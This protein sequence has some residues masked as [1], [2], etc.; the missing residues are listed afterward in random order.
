MDNEDNPSNPPKPVNQGE[1]TTDEMM[2][3]YFSYLNYQNG[4]EQIIVDTSSHAKHHLNCVPEQLSIGLKETI[5]H[6]TLLV[7]PN[8]ATNGINIQLPTASDFTL[9]MV[10]TLGQ[11]V[12]LAEQQSQL[13]VAGIANGIYFIKVT[14]NNKQLLQKVIIQR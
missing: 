5:P 6:Q 1:A 2:L 4:D 10:N 11:V 8:P 9:E 14:A 7:Y 3:V 13:N 12:L